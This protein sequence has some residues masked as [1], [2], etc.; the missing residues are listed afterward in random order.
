MTYYY[1]ELALNMYYPPSWTNSCNTELWCRWRPWIL[2]ARDW[3]CTFRG[4]SN[5][6]YIKGQLC[7]ALL[8]RALRII[9]TLYHSSLSYIIILFAHVRLIL[10]FSQF[11]LICKLC[12]WCLSC[13]LSTCVC[14][15]YMCNKAYVVSLDIRNFLTYVGERVESLNC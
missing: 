8:G 14:A 9:D 6:N 3:L 10:H 12:M 4:M 5:I 15:V 11:I 7:N 13:T 1:S 2:G